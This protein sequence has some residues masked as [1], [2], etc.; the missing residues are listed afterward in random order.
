V[1][2]VSWIA[3]RIVS[4]LNA[5]PR[6]KLVLKPGNALPIYEKSRIVQTKLLESQLDFDSILISHRWASGGVA[7]EGR[8]FHVAVSSGPVNPIER[9]LVEI[10]ENGDVG[11]KY[12]LGPNAARGIIRRVDSQGRTLFRPLDDA[13]RR[14]AGLDDSTEAA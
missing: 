8:A 9:Q 1:P 11:R 6:G 13:L 3:R 12:F 14:M 10:I 7:F 2:V 4:A 5:P